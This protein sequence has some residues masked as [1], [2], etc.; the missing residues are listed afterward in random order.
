MDTK[1]DSLVAGHAMWF[2]SLHLQSG[3][4][5][6]RICRIWQCHRQQR[7]RRLEKYPYYLGI[8]QNKVKK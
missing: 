8:L 7:C 3:A 4:V 6:N 5:Y 2:R 1:A